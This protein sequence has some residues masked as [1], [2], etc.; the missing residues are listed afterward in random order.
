MAGYNGLGQGVFTNATTFNDQIGRQ[1]D[2][3][4][5]K[6]RARN[7]DENLGVSRDTSALFPSFVA[8]DIYDRSVEE[9]QGLDFLAAGGN[10]DFGPTGVK[11]DN[12]GTPMF[13]NVNLQIDQ[14]NKKGPNLIAPDINN[15]TAPTAEQET[16]SF[17]NR[18]FGWKDGRNESG[19]E[20]ARIGEYFSKHY[21]ATGIDQSITRPKF[22][23]AKDPGTPAN[24]DA[25]N[26]DQP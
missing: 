7:V 12:D 24:P 26:Y 21:N 14:P 6:N 5:A 15:L 22:G 25:I 17:T 3:Y 1:R 23:E 10:P 8:Q 9:F 18:G 11:L 19:T 2:K 4:S 13:T 16:S 20:T